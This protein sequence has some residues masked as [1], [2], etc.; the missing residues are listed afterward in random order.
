LPHADA[1]DVMVQLSEAVPDSIIHDIEE[2]DVQRG[3]VTVHGIAPTIPD[4]QQIAAFLKNVRCF[5]DVKI[6]RTTQEVGGDRPKNNIEFDIKC[7]NE[8]KEKGAPAGAASGASSAG[9]PG[10]AKP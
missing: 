2:L 7:P 8:G 10:G 5:Q 6:V 1:F 4:A 3:H 9:T